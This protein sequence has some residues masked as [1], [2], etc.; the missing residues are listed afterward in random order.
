M[1]V[2]ACSSPRKSQRVVVKRNY[3]EMRQK[4]LS[5]ITPRCDM[6]MPPLPFSESEQDLTPLDSIAG[7]LCPLSCH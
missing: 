4:S 5:D 7:G 6:S 2:I 1:A 3:G